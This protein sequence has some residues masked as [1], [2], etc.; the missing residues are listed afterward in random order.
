MNDL[1]VSELRILLE[2]VL[3]DCKK[4]DISPLLRSKLV[5][6]YMK[7]HKISLSNM[8]RELCIP[9][10]TLHTW[11]NYGKITQEKYDEL[12]NSGLTK[13]QIHNIVKTPNK[14]RDINKKS[15][16]LFDLEDMLM[17]S[18]KIR[19]DTLPEELNPE[20]IIL[21]KEIVNELNR[22]LIKNNEI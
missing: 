5:D 3:I 18:R 19:R 15:P 4:P 2:N 17:R 7:I 16:Y 6:N 13:T 10:T 9:K 21:V 11:L 12:L 20:M 22:L 1:C 14:L 8:S